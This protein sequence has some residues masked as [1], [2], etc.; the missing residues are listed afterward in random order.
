MDNSRSC[1]VCAGIG[2][3]IHHEIPREGCTDECWTLVQCDG[4]KMVFLLERIEYQ[5]QQEE[6]EW[7]ETLELQRQRRHSR[8]LPAWLFSRAVC[9][10][11]QF[12]RLDR[13][14]KTLRVVRRHKPCGRLCDF[15]CG[16]GD[17][18]IHAQQS[19]SVWG[20]DI[21]PRQSARA[22]LRIPAA[23]IVPKPVTESNLQPASFD[24]VTMQSYIEHEQEPVAA[25]IAAR[26]AL[27]EDGI[28]VLKT[29]NYA[30]WNRKVQGLKWCGY[31]FPDHCNYFTKET[32]ALALRK[33]GLVPL[34]GPFGDCLPFSDN[35]YMAASRQSSEGMVEWKPAA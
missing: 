4:C 15:G 12:V 23:V 35:M 16:G 19:F 3:R 20:I 1:P 26:N 30:S 29:P 31:R 27:R 28:V 5:V 32:L 33:A 13:L 17:L 24:V 6:F 8:G 22:R 18:I 14:P 34:D 21:S 9:E 7:T 11:K 10:L 25:L 2:Q